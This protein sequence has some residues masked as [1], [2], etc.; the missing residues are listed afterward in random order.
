MLDPDQEN[1]LK[2]DFFIE[3]YPVLNDRTVKGMEWFKPDAF[4]SKMLRRYSAGGLKA[5]TD[6]RRVKQYINTAVKGGKQKVIARRREEFTNEPRLTIEHLAIESAALTAKVRE[7]SGAAKKLETL[8]RNISAMD[9][10]AEGELWSRLEGLVDL[11]R[12][13]LGEVERRVR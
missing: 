8:L 12:V 7:I 11:I 13:R 6:F 1:R 5:V 10:Y 4:T 2:A 9:F 3:L